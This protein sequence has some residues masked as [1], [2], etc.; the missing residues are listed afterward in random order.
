M[1][2]FVLGVLL[3][4][5][6]AKALDTA[7]SVPPKAISIHADFNVGVSLR[8]TPAKAVETAGA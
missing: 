3:S 8:K 5:T 4:K 2:I 1:L 7:A 6:P